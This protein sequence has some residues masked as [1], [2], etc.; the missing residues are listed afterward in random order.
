MVKSSG[1]T[2]ASLDMRGERSADVLQ[3]GR[4]ADP[5]VDVRTLD[6]LG[7]YPEEDEVGGRSPDTL[8]YFGGDVA[9]TDP[10]LG[11]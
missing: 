4:T 11:S 2:L 1:F 8:G 6:S 5:S 3:A 7:C 9:E 10:R